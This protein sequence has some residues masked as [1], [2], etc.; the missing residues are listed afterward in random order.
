M[1]IF[2]ELGPDRPKLKAA[3]F[4]FDGTISTLR[5]GWEH[6]MGPMMIEMISG[7][8]PADEALVREVGEYID[9]ST[10][11]QTIYQM[12][13]LADKV[14]E[15]G[16][17]P[18]G[19]KDEWQ[20]KAEYNRRLMK[21]VQERIDNILNG[22]RSADDYIVA[23]STELLDAFVKNGIEIYLASGTD[24]EDIKNEAGVLGLK[25]YFKEIAGA[26]MG[27][28][29]CSKEAVL[30]KLIDEKKFRGPEVVVIG[31]GKVEIALGRE[32]GAITLGVASDEEKSS[33]PDP[34]KRQRLIK[35]GAH[36][37]TDDLRNVDEI[38]KWLTGGQNRGR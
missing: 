36:A 28:A 9:A 6:I 22:T 35:A 24:D 14:R 17:G 19:Y 10:G 31:D 34:A 15:Y 37:V 27:K 33:G 29:D 25:G 21:P 12:R 3:L 4:D 30:R 11:I 2:I 13:W 32:V 1:E 18:E 5:Y 8:G 38:M 7:N 16:A 23:G 26:P 20:Y